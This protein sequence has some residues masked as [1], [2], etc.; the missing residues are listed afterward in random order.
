MCKQASLKSLLNYLKVFFEFEVLMKLSSSGF[1]HLSLSAQ[2][3][4]YIEGGI[5]EKP[6]KPALSIR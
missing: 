1:K 5:T 3:I 2:Y 6:S 4:E